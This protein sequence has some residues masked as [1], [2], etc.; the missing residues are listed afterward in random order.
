VLSLRCLEDTAFC[1]EIA[2]SATWEKRQEMPDWGDA[3]VQMEYDFTTV[4]RITSP[5]WG[6][7]YSVVCSNLPVNPAANCNPSVNKLV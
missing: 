4:D 6:F 1:A 7:T 5:I 2:V 3:E